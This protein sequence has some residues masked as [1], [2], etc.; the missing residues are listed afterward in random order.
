M[1]E[2]KTVASHFGGIGGYALSQYICP[3]SVFNDGGDITESEHDE[4]E[5]ADPLSYEQKKKVR[6][7]IG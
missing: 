3:Q 6:G 2:T 4:D 7:L 1:I 5:M